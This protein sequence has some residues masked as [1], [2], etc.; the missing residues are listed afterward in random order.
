MSLNVLVTTNHHK[1]DVAFDTV[2]V[3]RLD[4]LRHSFVR[5]AFREKVNAKLLQNY[6]FYLRD[7]HVFSFPE[8]HAARPRPRKEGSK[9]DIPIRMLIN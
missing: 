4:L 1:L 8:R 3:H 6:T 7:K 5:F 9:L 2:C